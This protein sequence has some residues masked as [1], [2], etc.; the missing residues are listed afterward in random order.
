MSPPSGARAWAVALSVDEAV[1]GG[2]ARG[3]AAVD[4]CR[5]EAEPRPS[6]DVVRL[7]VEACGTGDD[8]RRCSMI[9][10]AVQEPTSPTPTLGCGSAAGAPALGSLPP[11]LTPRTTRVYDPGVREDTRSGRWNRRQTSWTTTIH[12]DRNQDRTEFQLR[13][14]ASGD[15][16]LSGYAEPPGGPLFKAKPMLPA[17]GA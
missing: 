8:L 9:S 10:P 5:R 15:V 3:E 1:C 16:D 12:H 6:T 13:R 7:V 2:R 17:R 4:G 11:A 14:R